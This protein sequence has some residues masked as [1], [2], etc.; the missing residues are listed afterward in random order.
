MADPQVHACG[1]FVDVPDGDTTTR[2]P[3]TPV[4]FGGTPWQPRGMA[5]A[6]G[7]NTDDVLAELGRDARTVAGLRERGVVA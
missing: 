6:V 4:D 5:P 2:L 7:A 3:S 1:G